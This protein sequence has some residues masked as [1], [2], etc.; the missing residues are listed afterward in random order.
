MPI[1]VILSSYSIMSLS[2]LMTLQNPQWKYI[3]PIIDTVL[4]FFGLALTLIF[5]MIVLYIMIR[6]FQEFHT[7]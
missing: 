2:A 5:P 7:K 1:R 3:G 4:S 6:Y